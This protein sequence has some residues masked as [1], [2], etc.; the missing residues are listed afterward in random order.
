MDQDAL[1]T[2]LDDG[3]VAM[4]TLDTVDPEPLPAGH[5]LYE[6]PKVRL[7]AHISWASHLGMDST[8]DLFAANLRRTHRRRAARGRR[9]PR[10]G[11]LI[12]GRAV[13][14][15]VGVL[16][17]RLA[18]RR[19]ERLGGDAERDDRDRDD[20]LGQPDRRRG[21]SSANAVAIVVSAEPSPSAPAA[22][23]RFCSAG[24]IDEGT[25][26][27][28]QR[29]VSAATTIS[30]GAALIEPVAP[31]STSAS[32]AGERRP[33][34][35]ARP[36]C[37]QARAHELADP[38]PQLR[39]AHDDELP[40]LTVL[41]ARRVRRGFEHAADQLVGDRVV[42][43]APVRALR[44][45]AT[46]K[47]SRLIGRCSPRRRKLLTYMIRSSGWSAQWSNAGVPGSPSSWAT[48]G[49]IA[50]NEASGSSVSIS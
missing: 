22:S 7:S 44:A 5:W 46:A 40:G 26:A 32:S 2:A 11:L 50:W 18:P 13:A 43:E 6:H 47:K 12:P 27:G 8:V 21:S 14:V 31:R 30:T 37:S 20:R 3:R 49:V 38:L 48:S 41:R 19:A 28:R 33:S 25:V 39:V 42:G 15:A 16:G 9:R 24:K 34:E 4:A 35:C 17:E 36:C 10:R 23:S 1:R 45:R 29:A